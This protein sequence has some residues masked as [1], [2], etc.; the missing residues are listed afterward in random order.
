MEEH[1]NKHRLRHDSVPGTRQAEADAR[2]DADQFT[3]AV[4]Y[5]TEGLL[6]LKP[7]LQVSGKTGLANKSWWVRKKKFIQEF[8]ANDDTDNMPGY[9]LKKQRLE[10]TFAY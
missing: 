8:N 6:V 2:G 10:Q 3:S 5:N 1:E 7:N 4:C 9:V